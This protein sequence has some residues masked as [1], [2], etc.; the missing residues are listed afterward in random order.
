MRQT[1]L[2][3]IR[4]FSGGM[5]ILDDAFSLPDKYC[6]LAKNLITKNGAI[7]T[8]SGYSLYNNDSSQTGG[9]DMLL[10]YYK[11]N[12]DKYLIIANGDDYYYLDPD[13]LTASTSWTSIGDYGDAA[14]PRGIIYDDT[15]ILG[16]GSTNKLKKWDGTTFADTSSEPSDKVNIFF[17]YHIEN[18]RALVSS[19]R[20]DS[21]VYWCDPT[22]D[23]DDWSSGGSFDVVKN[24]G[25][26]VQG[27][28][29]I[30]SDLI[31]FKETRKYRLYASY[32]TD[33]STWTLRYRDE[34]GT[35]FGGT[36]SPDS[37]TQIY[38][39]IFYL[40]NEGIH[41]YGLKEQIYVGAV[42]HNVSRYIDDKMK[43][44]INWAYIYKS[45]GIFWDNN[46]YLA[47][48][49]DGS[50]FNSMVFVFNLDT[51]SWTEWTGVH[52]G[53]WTI[54]KDENEEEQLIYGD[55]VVP[56]IYKIS[57]DL[58]SNDL[59]PFSTDLITKK[60]DFGSKVWLKDFSFIDISGLMK[61]NTEI[62]VTV[63]TDNISIRYKIDNDNILS[64]T[65]EVAISSSIVGSAEPMGDQAISKR[66]FLAHIA[67]DNRQR[68]FREFYLRF[69]TGGSNYY[70]RLNYLA[71]DFTDLGKQSVIHRN[72]V[73]ILNPLT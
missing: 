32:D 37:I 40:S 31:V 38:K 25:E 41:S 30:G 10:P 62:I 56:K 1:G 9:I 21:T 52:V 58:Y 60:W 69:Q 36:R 20:G 7:E 29:Q 49:Y 19:K 63:Y 8:K 48:P 67:L 71:F 2:H 6:I 18:F 61:V 12:G 44:R 50:I 17:A 4:D 59:D 54:I 45:K 34:L 55:S 53:D 15:A 51:K 24:D 26:G 57:K 11:S 73:N 33:T 68:K 46:F 64:P 35:K 5:N 13:T 65:D 22:G 39:D 66:T 43:E 28:E 47:V 23:P 3:E 42:P 16:S 72:P 14:E 70:Y 27:F